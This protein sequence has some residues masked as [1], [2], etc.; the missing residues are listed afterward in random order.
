M[1][2]SYKYRIYPNKLQEELINKHIGSYRFIYNLALET[3]NAAYLGQKNSLSCFDLA[4]QLPDLK[5]E[6]E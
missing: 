6:C 1:L 2:K 5:K 4:K 3:K